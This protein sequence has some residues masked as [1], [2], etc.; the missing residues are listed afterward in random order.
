M[1]SK[2]SPFPAEIIDL[3]D[4]LIGTGA[5]IERKGAAMPYTS[6]NGNMFSFL[7]KDGM[8]H[9]RLPK[10]ERE[11]FIRD[12]KTAL[13]EQHGTVLK[14]YVAVPDDLFKD[15]ARLKVYFLKSVTYAKSLK[16]KPDKK[17]KG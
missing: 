4:S 15:T 8:L 3:Y 16:P 17:A 14:E 5:G 9:L 11:K 13:S 2:P 10:E 6:V 12:F 1:P 7:S